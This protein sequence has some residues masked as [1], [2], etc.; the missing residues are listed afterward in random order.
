M[1]TDKNTVFGA[2]SSGS[3][4]FRW[5]EDN[6]DIEE[7][8][9]PISDDIETVEFF[10]ATVHKSQI[11]DVLK[12]ISCKFPMKEEVHKFFDVSTVV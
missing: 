5:M 6:L 12:T 2:N 11:N 8:E 1:D 9:K 4:C 10:Y 7:V 3:I